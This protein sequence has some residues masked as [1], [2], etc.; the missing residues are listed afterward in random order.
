VVPEVVVPALPPL[1]E[2]LDEAAASPPP[3][4]PNRPTVATPAS[5]DS[6]RR[7]SLDKASRV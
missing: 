6:A 2:E 3:P 1:L 4:H 7:L 5:H